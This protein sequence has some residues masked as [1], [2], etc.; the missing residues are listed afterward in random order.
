MHAAQAE[1][2]R[3]AL[4][5]AAAAAAVALRELS[6][7]LREISNRLA[8]LDRTLEPPRDH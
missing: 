5:C 3:I 7:R 4:L 2:K 6:G 8:D 1:A